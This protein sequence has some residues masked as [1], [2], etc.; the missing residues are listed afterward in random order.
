MTS[1]LRAPSQIDIRVAYLMGVA[2]GAT[3]SITN[4]AAIYRTGNGNII[5][6]TQRSIAA[7][8][9]FRDMGKTV[10]VVN[11]AGIATARYRLVQLVANANAEG[12][13]VDPFYIKVWDAAGAGLVVARAG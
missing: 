11:A 13:L 2:S 5:S 4:P 7:G 10:T 8:D 9:L 6:S 3:Y 12:V 1:R